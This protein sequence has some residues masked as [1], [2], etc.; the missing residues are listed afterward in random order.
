MF[1]KKQVK[2][3][4][5][6][7][8][9]FSSFDLVTSS[10]SPSLVISLYQS[11]TRNRMLL[12]YQ[13]RRMTT[14]CILSLVLSSYLLCVSSETAQHLCNIKTSCG[15]LLWSVSPALAINL[16]GI[17]SD[18]LWCKRIVRV[19]PH[20]LPDSLVEVTPWSDFYPG[21]VPGPAML[22][23]WVKRSEVKNIAN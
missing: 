3:M 6:Q 4:P 13:T 14:N 8:S 9:A 2:R 11:E 22:K 23:S 20:V 15:S 7:Y 19:W 18:R 21:E 1:K 10:Y 17:S 12:Q 5:L 16:L